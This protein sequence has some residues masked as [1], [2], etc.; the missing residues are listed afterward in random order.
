MLYDFLSIDDI[1]R[2]MQVSSSMY[3]TGYKYFEH[4]WVN[5]CGVD[6]LPYQLFYLENYQ[7]A[8]PRNMENLTLNYMWLIVGMS[9][10]PAC[11]FIDFR[12]AGFPNM[13]PFDLSVD[14][15]RKAIMCYECDLYR[16]TCADCTTVHD[17]QLELEPA[18]LDCC[19]EKYQCPYGTC[20]WL[21]CGC[22]GVLDPASEI[23]VAF[24]LQR[25][26]GSSKRIACR[27]CYEELY[28]DS[29]I[30]EKIAWWGPTYENSR[31]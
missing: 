20:D 29:A 22:N 19:C 26:N 14:E 13:R 7:K 28:I 1:G 4:L 5:V 15:E 31:D 25:V 24:T 23:C 30:C 3:S 6:Y 18:C 27:G 12:R 9:T 21:C 11:R 2:A 8:W 16:R 10:C 17:E